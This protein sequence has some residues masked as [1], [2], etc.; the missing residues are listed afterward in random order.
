MVH[1]AAVENALQ[2]IVQKRTFSARARRR[3]VQAEM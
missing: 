3:A 1:A 2:G